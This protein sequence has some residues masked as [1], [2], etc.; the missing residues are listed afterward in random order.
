MLATGVI[1]GLVPAI[2]AQRLSAV[3]ALQGVRR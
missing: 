1:V 2:R 3:E